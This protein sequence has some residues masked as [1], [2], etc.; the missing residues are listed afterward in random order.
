MVLGG[1][2]QAERDRVTV[3]GTV[4][5]SM[6]QRPTM[7]PQP[8]PVV[9]VIAD[10]SGYTDF[11]LSHKKAVAHSQMIVRELLETLIREIDVPLKLIELEGDALFMYAA[12][13]VDP[14]AWELRG[15]R[16]VER[17]SKMFTSFGRSIVEIGSY[18]LCRCAACSNIT[19]LKLKIVA[20][21]G[22]GLLNEV[23]G[24]SI[25]SGVDTII[26]HR[27]LKNSVELDEYVLMTEEAHRDLP[28][29]DQKGIVEGSEQYDVGT[30]KT[31]LYRPEYSAEFD[32]VA[33]RESFSDSNVAVRILRDEIQREYTEVACDPSK[34]F[35]FNTGQRAAE[36]NEYDPEW[37]EPIPSDVVESFAGMGNPFSL[38][39][40]QPGE[41][42]V[43]VGSGAGL[44]SLIA[45][46]MVGVDGHVIGVE[47][48]AAMIEKA[49]AA[50]DEMGVDQIE[51]R[52][53]YMESLPVPDSWADVVISNGCINLAPDKS[54]VLNEMFRVLRPGGR[55]QIADV[56]VLKPVPHE[57]KQDIDLWTH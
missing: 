39:A 30:F 40:L 55:L 34:G 33:I 44:D 45:A 2:L 22:E 12:K 53:G 46:R 47:M 35:H 15:Q 3:P 43:D 56:T 17:I 24:F 18:S 10:I 38:G 57:A 4:S 25:L 20:H 23:G 37:I 36:I 26:V 16:I 48:T 7:D 9:L 54:R 51:F 1:V 32:E 21:S 5:F 29:P 27:L 42:V 28:F 11:M 31:F 19:E 8:T 49:R 52:D 6:D 14:G 41:H 13:T 50:A